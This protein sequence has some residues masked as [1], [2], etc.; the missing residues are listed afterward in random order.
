MGIIIR[1][2]NQHDTGR[3]TH[4][5]GRFYLSCRRGNDAAVLVLN[6]ELANLVIRFALVLLEAFRVYTMVNFVDAVEE[7]GSQR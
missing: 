6:C 7:V 2:P 1:L 4:S 3:E 5:N